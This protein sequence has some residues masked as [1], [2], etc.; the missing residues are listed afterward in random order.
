MIEKPPRV[1][2]VDDET[3][4]CELLRD[5]LTLREYNCIT[6][7]NAADALT[8]LSENKFDAALLDICLPDLSGI[9]LLK[10]IHATYPT[11]IC[12]MLTAVNDL[13]LAVEAM[14]AGA[15]DYI[16]KPFDLDRVNSA[17]REAFANR[18]TESEYQN[19]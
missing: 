16:T 6:A 13:N 17:L 1:L 12:I 14:K 18:A 7:G 8:R 2:I 15:V 4:I 9:E 11:T 10:K 19:A 3:H 5:D